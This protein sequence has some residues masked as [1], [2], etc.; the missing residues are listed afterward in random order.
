M[1]GISLR[2]HAPSELNIVVLYSGFTE[3]IKILL[4]REAAELMDVLRSMS[5]QGVYDEDDTVI[6]WGHVG[7]ISWGGGGNMS[8]DLCSCYCT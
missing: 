3:V 1:K 5:D 4:F 2:S 6:L 7:H 8:Q